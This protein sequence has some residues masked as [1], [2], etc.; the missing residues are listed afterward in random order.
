MRCQW[1]TIFDNLQPW[2]SARR[3]REFDVL[4]DEIK[5]AFPA[6]ASNLPALPEKDYFRFLG[7][8]I[9]YYL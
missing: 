1:G 7:I 5:K 8:Y 6:Y 2:I 4:N 9:Y 3:Y